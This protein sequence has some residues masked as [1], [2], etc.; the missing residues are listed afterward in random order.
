[1]IENGDWDDDCAT[2]Q[3]W[4]DPSAEETLLFNKA[5]G[6]GPYMLDH[7]TPGE[8]IV[9]TANE[10]YWRT[11]PMWEGGPSGPASI[12][13]VVIK[14]IDEWGTRLAMF[15]AGDAD[16]IY[17][18]PQ[19]RPQLEPFYKTVCDPDGHLRRG[20]IPTATSRPTVTSPKSP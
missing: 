6:T 5:N 14:N 19:Y 16:Y 17:V 12:K 3:N 7:W 15:E 8:E 11:E 4:A 9:L 20:S 2:W 13:R 18:P 10:N 1:M